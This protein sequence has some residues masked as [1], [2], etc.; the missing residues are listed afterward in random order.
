MS[1]N[2]DGNETE[3]SAFFAQATKLSRKKQR[4]INAVEKNK[5]E[6]RE[7]DIQHWLHL[8]K[9]RHESYEDGREFS[10][11]KVPCG[12]WERVD[13]HWGQVEDMIG[14]VISSEASRLETSG[15]SIVF[16]IE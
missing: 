8:Y 15:G 16:G 2:T 14:E 11:A 5:K 12:A 10:L 9:K 3:W 1:T 13:Y 6:A 4:K 7:R